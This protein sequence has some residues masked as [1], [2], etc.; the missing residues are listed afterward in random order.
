MLHA[1]LHLLHFVSKS[2]FSEQILSLA[3]ALLIL[4][5]SLKNFDQQENLLVWTTGEDPTKWIKVWI[6]HW[7]KGNSWRSS[8]YF[9]SYKKCNIITQVPWTILHCFF[10]TF[11]QSLQT[12][13]ITR[14][15]EH[16]DKYCSTHCVAYS[17]LFLIPEMIKKWLPAVYKSD[18]LDLIRLCKNIKVKKWEILDK[19][20]PVK[21]FL[22]PS[23]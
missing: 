1:L 6:Y 21:C 14:K 4:Q 19:A 18:K 11:N 12:G 8:E 7:I 20:I 23:W 15:K 3:G 22:Y 10:T 17:S 5:E 2:Y 13:S 16:I 9:F